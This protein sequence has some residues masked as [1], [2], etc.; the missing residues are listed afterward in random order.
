MRR[1]VPAVLLLLA[2]LVAVLV[3]GCGGSAGGSSSTTGRNGA[4]EAW[5]AEVTA[6]MSHVGEDLEALQGEFNSLPPKQSAGEAMYA[7]FSAKVTALA[8]EVEAIEA[9]AECAALKRK[10]VDLTNQVA[11][12]A[13]EL[14]DQKSMTLSQYGAFAHNKIDA[15]SPTLEVL[16]ETSAAPRC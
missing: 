12:F 4:E 3:A 16:A 14:G 5:A 9:P 10:I 7:R 6:V 15:I 11:A 1:L 2:V 13:T 8:A